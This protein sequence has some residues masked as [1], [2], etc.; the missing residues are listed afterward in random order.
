VVGG[1]EK[2]GEGGEATHKVEDDALAWSKS[3]S[4]AEQLCILGSECA[5]VLIFYLP[6]SPPIPPGSSP[7]GCQTEHDL[8]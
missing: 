2:R 8:R 4:G 3:A 6:F 1:S 5:N 7:R